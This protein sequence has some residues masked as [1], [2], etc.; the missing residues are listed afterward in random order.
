MFTL[1]KAEELIYRLDDRVRELEVRSGIRQADPA[2]ANN[3][4]VAPTDGAA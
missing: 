2:P 3:P 1:E 4:P